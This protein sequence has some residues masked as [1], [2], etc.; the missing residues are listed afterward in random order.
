MYHGAPAEVTLAYGKDGKDG[1]KVK[2][3]GLADVTVWNPGPKV[4]GAMADMEDGG[5]DKYIWCVP[6]CACRWRKRRRRPPVP[7]E[8]H[9]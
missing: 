6:R 2:S 1:V 5:W 4:G 7:R 3:S 9:R 8:L